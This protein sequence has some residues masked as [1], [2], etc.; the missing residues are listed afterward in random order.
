MQDKIVLIPVCLCMYNAL[1]TSV[2]SRLQVKARKAGHPQFC[3]C[4]VTSKMSTNVR[5]NWTVLTLSCLAS[6]CNKLLLIISCNILFFEVTTRRLSSPMRIRPESSCF[7]PT[8]TMFAIR[9]SSPM[10]FVCAQSNPSRPI[11][12]KSRN[13]I[14]GLF[15]SFL[16]CWTVAGTKI[17]ALET[18]LLGFLWSGRDSCQQK[19]ITALQVCVFA[20]ENNYPRLLGFS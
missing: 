16:D 5:H 10:Q 11:Q 6:V 12:S 2:T 19:Y 17:P 3:C 8:T 13:S 15:G 9:V 20:R 14:K 4:A 1:T 7:A 18:M